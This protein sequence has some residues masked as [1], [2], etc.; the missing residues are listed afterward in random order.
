MKFIYL[1]S[2]IILLASCGNKTNETAATQ[3]LPTATANT[4][5]PIPTDMLINLFENCSAI[6]FIFSSLPF[7]ISQDD[8]PSIQRT[9]SHINQNPPQ[10]IDNSCPYF[11]QQI[12]QID[13]EIVLDAKIFFLPKCTYYL[14]YEEGVAKYSASF[15]N[16]GVNFYN[17]LI[18]QA[19]QTSNNG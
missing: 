14:F 18:E 1:S 17:S 7:S 8:K 13:G 3:E 11:A 12:F 4:L 15:T 19:K 2:F 6:D 9:I 5:P 16:E 10:S